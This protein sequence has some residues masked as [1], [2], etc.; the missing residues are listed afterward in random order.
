MRRQ[1]AAGELDLLYV[2]PE[3]LLGR[4]L[5]G[6]ARPA[7]ARAVR[8]RRGALHLAMGPR[9]PPGVSRARRAARRWP[10]VPRI[11]LTA[12]ADPPTRR[13]IA[14]ARPGPRAEFVG[15]FDRPNIRYR[16]RPRATAIAQLVRFLRA[17]PRA[18]PRSSTASRASARG[19][20][21]PRREGWSALPYHAG[22]AP[23]DRRA[24]QAAS[25]A[26]TCASSSPRS[27]SAWASTSP[28]CASSTTTTCPRA[29]SL[30][31]ET[32]RAG[33]DGLPAVAMMTWGL[34]DVAQLRQ[35]IAA[36]D[37][38]ARRRIEHHKLGALLGLCETRA[39]AVRCC[40]SISAT[41][42]EPCGNC[43]SCLEPAQRW[44]G[45]I[46]S[47]KALSAVR[48]TGERFGQS[49]LIDLLLGQTN[50]RMARARPRPAADV[51]RR[52]R[53]RP[54]HLAVGLPP[55]GG[56]RPARGRPRGLRRPAPGGRRRERPARPAP[57]RAAPRPDAATR[58]HARAKGAAKAAPAS[59]AP[60]DLATDADRELFEALRSRRRDL[61]KANGIA[62]FMVFPDRTL[63]ELAQQ[64]PANLQ[65]LGTIHGIG[66][67]KRE[68]WGEEFLAVIRRFTG[69]AG[70]L[71]GGGWYR[72]PLRSQVRAP[73]AERPAAPPAPLGRA[74]SAAPHDP[75]PARVPAF[76]PLIRIALACDRARA[77]ADPPDRHS[78]HNAS[79][80]PARSTGIALFAGGC[81]DP[82]VAV[83]GRPD[84]RRAARRLDPSLAQRRAAADQRSAR[85]P[86]D[87][88]E[89]SHT[90]AARPNAWMP[91]GCTVV[92]GS[93]LVVLSRS[94]A[95]QALK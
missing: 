64:K 77:D 17:S 54:P 41:L 79:V 86:P 5:P 81:A 66:Q 3:R 73:L 15:G 68:R 1:A 45:T 82:A 72:P 24:T 85:P 55:A 32:G 18:T 4:R 21:P 11:A 10:D 94:R 78:G 90:A 20:R 74:I 53:P 67:T 47:Q 13:E 87:A 84:R 8:D 28:T 9:L 22:L 51:R 43:D 60:A 83:L 92:I 35:F 56:G 80:N 46:A 38:E 44:D 29:S 42:A 37:N 93:G 19:D 16:V 2:A 70:I 91:T 75:R 63:L 95:R 14:P 31:Q 48:R 7:A 58:P 23:D 39:A 25:S 50:E 27:P 33:R 36:G 12:T 88:P 34:A 89:L 76:G 62:P 57:G 6:L 59:L 52:L 65:A 71:D 69:T 49:Y 40:C 30:Y 61:A 26:T